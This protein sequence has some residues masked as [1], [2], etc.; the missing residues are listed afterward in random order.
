MLFTVNNMPMES[1]SNKTCEIAGFSHVH[2]GKGE[3]R[4]I[5]LGNT[6]VSAWDFPRYQV[7]R[8]YIIG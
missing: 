6:A 3:K 7:S 1:D 8:A 4:L 2:W 5:F